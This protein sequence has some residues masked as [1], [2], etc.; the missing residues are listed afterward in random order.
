MLISNAQQVSGS[1]TAVNVDDVN[2]QSDETPQ[3]MEEARS[4]SQ[5][6][7]RQ[8]KARQPM[9]LIS[10]W[11]SIVGEYQNANN[12]CCTFNIPQ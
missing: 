5:S 6:T 2:L 9:T 10:C 1:G 7:E 4:N 12:N 11:H 3:S 8:R